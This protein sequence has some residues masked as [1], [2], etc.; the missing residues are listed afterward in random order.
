MEEE[1]KRLR[2]CLAVEQE[3]RKK[4]VAALW[5]AM[6]RLA[7][8]HTVA[9]PPTVETAGSEPESDL[10]PGAQSGEDSPT[11]DI[12]RQI[13]AGDIDPPDVGYVAM[14]TGA[15]E[16]VLQPDRRG[17]GLGGVS[18]TS[19]PGTPE[20]PVGTGDESPGVAGVAEV[21]G[22]TPQAS[23]AL[24]PGGGPGAAGLVEPMGGMPQHLP[25]QFTERMGAAI[26]DL[27]VHYDVF[28]MGP[29]PRPRIDGSAVWETTPAFRLERRLADI[30]R[31][32]EREVNGGHLIAVGR[33]LCS[34]TRGEAGRNGRQQDV[35][36]MEPRWFREDGVHLT[37]AAYRRISDKLPW[38]LR[39]A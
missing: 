27:R 8:G 36:R 19:P 38:W 15:S 11:G 32:D 10:F 1:L 30:L 31:G 4:E 5:R 18:R 28:V 33:R 26:A 39:C 16:G 13:L 6:K 21:K 29:T 24:V 23:A 22:G 35:Y 3:E 12:I 25:D 37:A 14:E 7:M 20:A 9:F 2:T 34:R 17:G